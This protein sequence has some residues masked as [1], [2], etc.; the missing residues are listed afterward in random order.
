[1]IKIIAF[2]LIN[3]FTMGNS[4]AADGLEYV[5]IEKP[6]QKI[7]IVKI[8]LHQYD[9]ALVSA[10]NR[11]FGREKAGDIAERENAEVAINAGFF[12]IGQ[13]E[14]G[15][16]TGT[17]IINGEIFGLRT[18]NHAVFAVRNKI[19]SIEMWHPKI[20]L[21]IAQNKFIPSKYNKFVNNKS[22]I[23]YSDKWGHSTLTAFNTR[24]E[25]T[26]SKDKKVSNLANHG[27]NVIPSEGYVLSL[28]K[29][30]DISF[31]KIDDFVQFNEEDNH[32]IFDKSTSAIMGIPFLIMDGIVNEK[33]SD[34]EKHARTAIGVDKDRKIIVT[35]VE[36]IYTKSPSSLTLRETQDILQKKNISLN[37]LQA[38]DVKK[39]LLKE[40]SNTN[41]AEGMGLKELAHLMLEQGCISAI[42][43]DGGGSSTLYINGKYVNEQV[44]D[45]DEA[46]GLSEVR[47]LSDAIIFKKNL[48]TKNK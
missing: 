36:C 2:L 15:R 30:Q 28:P 39:I 38:A 33:L 20:E 31:I 47:P 32:S 46:H 35:V 27:N 45:K 9:V 26:I 34:S 3:I 21:E 42:N 1:M 17:L 22:V 10:H 6:N 13:N 23:L 8:D 43:L 44:G 40:L 5:F 37:N 14:D 4:M 41:E 24:N 18:T 48:K 16:P 11:V 19:P 7:H 12:Q 25:I 29:S